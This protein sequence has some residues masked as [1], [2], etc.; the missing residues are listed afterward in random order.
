MLTKYGEFRI[1]LE[2][3]NRCLNELTEKEVSI[4]SSRK[5]SNCQ[6]AAVQTNHLI[7]SIAEKVQSRKINQ[8]HYL[9]SNNNCEKLTQ[10]QKM[11]EATNVQY[12]PGR[13]I[14]TAAYLRNST[15]ESQVSTH[16]PVM[17]NEMKTIIINK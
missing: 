15:T 16:K 4:S 9:P 14:Q 8:H 6:S 5:D 10:S 7:A 3:V 17:L 12:A 11:G 2:E 13:L 1:S